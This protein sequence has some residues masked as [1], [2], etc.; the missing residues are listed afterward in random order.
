MNFLYKLE[1]K[2]GKY[3]ISNL[4]LYLILCY[5]CG[6]LMRLINPAFLNYLTLDTYRILHGQVWRI[7]TWILVPPDSLDFFTLIMLYF[8][9]SIGTSLE[10]TWGTFLYNV[11]MFL[12]MIFTVVGSFV[13]M[14]L[15]YLV[16][17]DIIAVGGAEAFFQIA[18]LSFSTYY[19]NMSIFLAFAATFPNVQVLLMFIIPI[20][21]KW[22]GVVYAVLLLY[23]FVNT[24]MIGKVSI[25]ASLL[26]F[27]VFFLLTR[28]GLRM[29]MSP[30]QVKRRHDFQREVKKA[31]PMSVA[32]HKCAIC[33]RTSEEY[34]E[35]E[36]RFCSKCN[37]NYE[38]CQEHLFTHTHVK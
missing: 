38:Y 4:S 18:A 13:A 22:L 37:G 5:G 31:K 15:S 8:Y 20:K 11:Y 28:R 21:V 16:W 17:G 24:W 35:L 2:F 12:G 10:R 34:P 36:F 3:A 23:E 25:L 30:K 29:R 14:G 9:Y 33:G 6:Y 1:R 19:I 27:V 7:V 32:R 26:N